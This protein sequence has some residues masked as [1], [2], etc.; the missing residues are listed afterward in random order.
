MLAFKCPHC[1]QRLKVD[2]TFA[3]R[4]AKCGKCKQKLQVPPAGPAPVEPV[5]A[6]GLATQVQS[7]RP[8]PVLRKKTWPL[9]ILAAVVAT[10]SVGT[11]LFLLVRPALSTAPEQLTTEQPNADQL[12]SE[13]VISEQVLRGPSGTD[14]AIAAKSVSGRSQYA[15]AVSRDVPYATLQQ[16]LLDA[17][18]PLT[19]E[20][21]ASPDRELRNNIL[22]WAILEQQ[23][24]ASYN[25]VVNLKRGEAFYT[26]LLSSPDLMDAIMC[27][28]PLPKPARTVEI[29]YLLYGTD[30][31]AILSQAVLQN[32][33]CA[34]AAW[35]FDN[36]RAYEAYLFWKKCWQDGLLHKE[37]DNYSAQEMRMV[38]EKTSPECAADMQAHHNLPM[39]EIGRIAWSVPYQGTNVFSFDPLIGPWEHCGTWPAMARDYG[40]VCGTVSYYGSAGINARGLMS[41]PGEQPGHCAYEY[42]KLDG[43][44]TIGN[45]VARPTGTHTRLLPLGNFLSM[46]YMDDL[47]ADQEAQ[48]QARTLE[49]LALMAET[50][51]HPPLEVEVDSCECFLFDP[52]TPY[53]LDQREPDKSVEAASLTL[54]VAPRDDFYAIRWKGRITTAKDA[55]VSVRLECDDSI[56]LTVDGTQLAGMDNPGSKDVPLQ[57]T[58][59]EHAFQLDFGERSGRAHMKCEWSRQP[60]PLNPRIA[61][62]RRAA[63][64]AC[65]LHYTVLKNWG[66]QIVSAS[67]FSPEELDRWVGHV[68]EHFQ[69]HPENAWN[70]IFDIAVPAISRHGGNRELLRL[71]ERANA[72]LHDI[73]EEFFHPTDMIFENILNRMAKSLAGNKDDLFRLFEVALAG[74]QEAKACFSDV[75][76]WG[77]GNFLKDNSYADRYSQTVSELFLRKNDQDG[78]RGFIDQAIRTAQ[79]DGDIPAFRAA[80]S[81]RD[82]LQ[83]PQLTK[84][85]PQFPGTLLSDA[86]LFKMERYHDSFTCLEYD[87]V[88]REVEEGRA[89]TFGGFATAEVILAGD[90]LVDGIYIRGS[91]HTSWQ[92]PLKVMVSADGKEW[93]TVFETAEP[94]RDWRVDLSKQPVQARYVKLERASKNNHFEL[95]KVLVYGKKLY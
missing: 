8:V 7:R 52:A 43:N 45:Y 69:R 94:A 25:R 11:G 54:A 5:R 41:T 80:C 89:R 71:Y 35:G 57:L 95:E 59:G 34:I 14:P 31:E 4:K 42:R 66:N 56:Y 81:M 21:S 55:R 46:E 67:V 73:P 50:V 64:A 85:K 36:Y 19:R 29:M 53:D 20:V 26:W 13:Q 32:L 68:L 78:L 92:V 93:K 86:G 22:R 15:F 10:V 91:S 12:V 90:C 82:Q 74:Q 62:I 40:G 33:A 77:A 3:G 49:Y 30:G 16:R 1:G 76:R 47:F 24:K 28:G 6:N 44:W 65:P 72:H 38:V 37:F 17:V 48:R 87:Y 75:L 39:T 88:I 84:M 70:L 63:A 23:G 79:R 83:L 2:K 61:A 58:A 51:I 60:E 9:V 18:Q 27:S